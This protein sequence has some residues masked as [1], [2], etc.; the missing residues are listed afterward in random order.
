MSIANTSILENFFGG[1]AAT[2]G[3]VTADHVDC[4]PTANGELE[5]RQFPTSFLEENQQEQ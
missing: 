3:D 5:K 1:S 2:V 4:Q